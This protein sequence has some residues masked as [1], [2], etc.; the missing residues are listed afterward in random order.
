MMSVCGV[1]VL[2]LYVAFAIVTDA[3]GSVVSSTYVTVA[4]EHV[5]LFPYGSVESALNV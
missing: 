2:G 5:D 4:V 1:N 3:D